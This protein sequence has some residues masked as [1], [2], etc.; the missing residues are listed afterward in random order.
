MGSDLPASKIV[1]FI[2]GD[3]EAAWNA[4][5]AEPVAGNRGNFLFALQAMVLLE[6]ASRLCAS[7]LTGAALG[8]FSTQLS[9]RDPRYFTAL[10][11]A[12]AGGSHEFTLPCSGPNPS[13]EL[14]AALFDLIRN[15][16]AHQ[17]Q[18]IRVRLSDGMDFQVE[19]T[20]A[21]HGLFLDRTPNRTGHL[22]QSRDESGDL[23]LKVRTDVLFVDVRE[24]IRTAN[25]LGR[26]LSIVHLVRPRGSG[27]YQFSSAQL[28][29]ALQPT[30]SERSTLGLRLPLV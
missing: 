29:Q 19:L 14:L 13:A 26:G 1:D 30:G 12:C 24:S 17:Y 16:Q 22:V 21:E 25:L 23:W 11:G 20:G 9:A 8:A 7:D 15:G 5:A 2:I 10:P 18:Q 3:F 6:V 27:T 4:L 28:E